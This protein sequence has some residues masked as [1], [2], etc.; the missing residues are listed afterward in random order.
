MLFTSP[1]VPSGTLPTPMAITK[2]LL[3]NGTH[4]YHSVAELCSSHFSPPVPALTS[5]I[6]FKKTGKRN[7][8]FLATKF[9]FAHGEPGRLVKADPKYVHEALNKSLSRLGVDCVDLY[10]AH[11]ADPTVPIEHTVGAMAKLVRWV[12]IPSEIH[13]SYHSSVAGTE[14]LNASGSPRFQ[15]P[16]FVGRTLYIPFL[17]SRLNIPP[18]PWTSRM[19]LSVS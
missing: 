9:G 11:R 7:E 3:E 4:A 8:I 5:A 14:R 1:G 6:R 16:P 18:S 12:M 2:I 15:F 10:Y 13:G 17:L 19:N